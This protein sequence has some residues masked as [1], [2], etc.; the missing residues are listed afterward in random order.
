MKDRLTTIPTSREVIENQLLVSME[1][2]SK[3]ALIL[4]CDDLTML[5][6]ALA[7]AIDDKRTQ[8][9]RDLQELRHKAF[10]V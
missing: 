10:G 5:I 9:R 6:D 7:Y 3:V 8:M 1:D 4:T 2:K